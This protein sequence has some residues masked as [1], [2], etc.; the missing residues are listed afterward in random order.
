[1]VWILGAVGT[2]AGLLGLWG[3][4]HPAGLVAVPRRRT[5]QRHPEEQPEARGQPLASGQ[6]SL[7][8]SQSTSGQDQGAG[9][10]R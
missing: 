2:L 8:R 1:M 7:P 9:G 10:A 5:Q 6:G 4:A 3:L